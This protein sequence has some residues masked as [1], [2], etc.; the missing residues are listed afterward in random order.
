MAASETLPAA[1]AIARILRSPSAPC[2]AP[3]AFADKDLYLVV[4]K[5]LCAAPTMP[6]WWF[7]PP[8]ASWCSTTAPTGS[9]IRARCQDYKPVLTFTAGHAYTHGYR[10]E[11]RR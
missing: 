1:A 2:C 8:A 10:R 6:C 7:A 4:L 3:P 9:S 11:C 5:D